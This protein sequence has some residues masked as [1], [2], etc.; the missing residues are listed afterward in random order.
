MFNFFMNLH[1]IYYVNFYYVNKD[2]HN[3]LDNL[4]YILKNSNMFNFQCYDCVLS[5]YVKL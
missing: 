2:F 4:V 3:I 5:C 1:Q